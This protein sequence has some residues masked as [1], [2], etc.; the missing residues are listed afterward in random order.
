MRKLLGFVGAT[1]GGYIGW[2]AGSRVGVMTAFVL[3]MIGTGV[4]M[5]LAIRV[6]R[7]YE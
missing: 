4:G 5:Y 3:S 2:W 1:I 6:V 7:E